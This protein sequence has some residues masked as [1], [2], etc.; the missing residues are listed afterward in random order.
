MV[1]GQVLVPADDG[2]SPLAQGRRG[3][4]AYSCHLLGS[5]RKGQDE[6][7]GQYMFIDFLPR[8]SR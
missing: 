1:R 2:V 8:P 7:E 4:L 5:K 6:S 3:A